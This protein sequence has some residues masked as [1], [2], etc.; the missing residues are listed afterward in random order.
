MTAKPE[1]YRNSS[2]ITFAVTN[3]STN[4][5]FKFLF[6]EVSTWACLSTVSRLMQYSV[7]AEALWCHLTF[8]FTQ[9]LR[10]CQKM[11]VNFYI[12][13]N[14]TKCSLMFLETVNIHRYNE[15][16]STGPSSSA[17]WCILLSCALTLM[18]QLISDYISVTL[19]S[20]VCISPFPRC[21][22]PVYLASENIISVVWQSAV[23]S[24]DPV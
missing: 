22:D 21:F 3:A 23:R 6:V 16:R 15:A 4:F 2:F 18:C 5:W 24:S 8:T 12:F 10:V 14:M 9:R 17:L 1:P 20:V 11:P 7:S 13:Y 19:P